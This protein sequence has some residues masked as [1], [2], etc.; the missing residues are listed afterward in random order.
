MPAPAKN[1]NATRHGLRAA[2]LPKGSSYITRAT[3]ELRRAIEDAVATAKG[4][5]NIID[6][7]T[8]QTIMRHE[9][10]A[11]LAQRW[12]KKDIENMTLDQRLKYSAEIGRA[13]AE[14]DKCLRSL[15]IGVSTTGD[16]LAEAYRTPLTP[17]HASADG[18]ATVE[19]LNGKRASNAT[20]DAVEA[21]AS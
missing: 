13:S 1:R 2:S 18:S 5:V 3:N 4:G 12:L 15:G 6:A 19:P 16:V 10:H 20:L 14:R 7:A 17:A 11:M 8:I 9:R 21:K